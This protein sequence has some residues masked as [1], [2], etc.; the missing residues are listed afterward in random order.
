MPECFQP[1]KD[2]QVCFSCDKTERGKRK[3]PKCAKCHAITYCGKECQ[4]T[5]WL[6]HKFNCVPVL[7][8]EI[9]GKGRGLVAARDIEMGEEIFKDKPIIRLPSIEI[10]CP[11]ASDSLMKQIENLPSEAKSLFYKLEYRKSE[12]FL[13]DAPLEMDMF[14]N[15]CTILGNETL[16]YLNKLDSH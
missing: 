7:V 13:L 4:K 11:D 10:M 6:R 12:S 5:D 9:P 3:F 1:V 15:N 14:F 16:L 2:Y 8:T